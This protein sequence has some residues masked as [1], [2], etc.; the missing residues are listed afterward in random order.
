MQETGKVWEV[1]DISVAHKVKTAKNIGLDGRV[2]AEAVKAHRVDD[3]VLAKI[4]R[5]NSFGILEGVNVVKMDEPV[6]RS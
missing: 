3:L 4:V 1:Q 2:E 5:M 6:G